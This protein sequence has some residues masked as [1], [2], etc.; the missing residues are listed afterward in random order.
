MQGFFAVLQRRHGDDAYDADEH[1]RFERLAEVFSVNADEDSPTIVATRDRGAAR[2]L[3]APTRNRSIRGKI[4]R[5]TRIALVISC[6]KERPW[7]VSYSLRQ[8][9]NP[10][11]IPQRLRKLPKLLR[12][13]G[14]ELLALAVQHFGP[15]EQF[16]MKQLAARS[17]LDLE[18]ILSKNRTFALSCDRRH[19]RKAWIFHP[20]G[21]SPR[22]F[23]V[24]KHHNILEFV[25]ENSNIPPSSGSEW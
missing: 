17:G 20:H 10:S 9:G 21:G 18:T 24:A 22:K 11:A 2:G 12:L 6:E 8:H 1:T 19:L 23:S 15:D 13:G 14:G 3:F 25:F 7:S 4:S 16:D 5:A